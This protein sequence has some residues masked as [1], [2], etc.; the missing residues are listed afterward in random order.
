IFNAF[1]RVDK[2]RNRNTGGTGLGLYIVKSILNQH[3]N[4][5][6]SMYNKEKSVV[7]HIKFI[8]NN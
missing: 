4:I 7:F 6:Y 5:E 8:D 3:Y 1:Y 2:S